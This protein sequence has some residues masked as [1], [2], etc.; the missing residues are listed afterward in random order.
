[1]PKFSIKNKLVLEQSGTENTASISIQI[2]SNHSNP[3]FNHLLTQLHTLIKSNLN[4]Y[5]EKEDAP[6]PKPKDKKK[7]KFNADTFV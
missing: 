2:D 6:K 3:S 1:M 7:N 5:A 4:N